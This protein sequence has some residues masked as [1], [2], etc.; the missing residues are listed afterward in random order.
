M[1]E[2]TWL[3]I[4]PLISAVK[5]GRQLV[6]SATACLTPPLLTGVGESSTSD[7]IGA[8][9]ASSALFLIVIL[10]IVLAV[11]IMWKVNSLREDGSK[12][13]PEGEISDRPDVPTRLPMVRPQGRRKSQVLRESEG[14]IIRAQL[15]MQLEQE[16]QDARFRARLQGRIGHKMSLDVENAQRTS[17]GSASSNKSLPTENKEPPGKLPTIR[18]GPMPPELPRTS[19]GFLSTYNGKHLGGPST[20]G[21]ASELRR[22][23]GSIMPSTVSYRAK[24]ESQIAAEQLT[25]ITPGLQQYDKQSS[26]SSQV[27]TLEPQSSIRLDV[28]SNDF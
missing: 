21:I 3:T 27:G 6:S 12:V 28:L 2:I 1:L 20:I 16:V 13:F 18:S 26:T 19:L 14:H 17:T 8:I 11:L 10:I 22:S 7:T 15:A 25:N 5:P 23:S 9:Y 24:T 4:D